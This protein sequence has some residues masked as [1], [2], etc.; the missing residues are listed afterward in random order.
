MQTQIADDWFV[1]FNT[2]LKAKFWRAASEP[3]ADDDAQAIAALLELPAGA[4]VLDAPC[5]A[6]RIAV[7]LA[8][9]G[10]DV[11]GIDISQEEI[12]EARRVAA[13]RGAPAW[14]EQG[15]IRALPEHGFDVVVCWGNSFGYLPHDGTV[16]H[17]AST[18]RALRRGGRLVLE[19]MTVAESLLPE[20]RSE[21][22][23]EAGGV[24]MH[25]RHE[26]DVRHSRLL[27][28]FEFAAGQGHSES[29]PVI[30]HVYTV[31]EVVRLLEAAG[32]RVDE[33]LG[34]AAERSPYVLGAPRLV[35]LATA[36]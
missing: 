20:F 18:R 23:Y 30:H 15:D 2:G 16:G 24:T 10:L 25:A 26:Y 7:R 29:G 27:G 1:G 33:L 31:A 4:R 9:R 14:F 21:I 19:S 34:D 8:E 36:L 3:W 17:L 6:G 11:V 5:G 12:E 32:F 22:E 28:D 35:A 13:D